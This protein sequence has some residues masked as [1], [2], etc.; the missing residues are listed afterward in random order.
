LKWILVFPIRRVVVL[1]VAEVGDEVLANL[2][3]HI[4]PGA[5]DPLP[6][7]QR[8]KPHQPDRKQHPLTVLH[9]AFAGLGNL[10]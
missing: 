8:L 9:L 7:A 2:L 4:L 5:V 1:P 3:G 6:I 10:G